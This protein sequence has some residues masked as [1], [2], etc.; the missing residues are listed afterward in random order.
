MAYD[1]ILR[2]LEIIGEAAKNIPPEIRSKYPE[3]DWRGMAGLRDVMAHTYYAL[4]DET[5][6]SIVQNRVPELYT[7]AER[8]LEQEENS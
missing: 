2:N 4:Q 8:I 1:A 3:V 6:W 7:S 5:L